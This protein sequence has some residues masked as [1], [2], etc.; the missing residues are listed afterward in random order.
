MNDFGEPPECSDT[1]TNRDCERWVEMKS[2]TT[3]PEVV[4]T[5]TEIASEMGSMTN[6]PNGPTIHPLARTPTTRPTHF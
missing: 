6:S 4:D 2:Q 1:A 5:G 3:H